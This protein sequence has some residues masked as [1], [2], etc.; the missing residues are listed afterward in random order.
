MMTSW[1]CEYLA[2]TICTECHGP[3]LRGQDGAP[4]LPKALG[5]TLP[6]FTALLW[7]GRARDGRDLGL[8][9]V[10]ARRRFSRLSRDE[11]HALW[12]CLQTLSLGAP[13]PATR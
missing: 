7:D 1:P 5:Y 11:I 13:A 12:A 6:Q 4:A 9:A 10:T 2:T 8:M 3:D